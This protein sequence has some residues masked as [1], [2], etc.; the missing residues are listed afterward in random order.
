MMAWP[1]SSHLR[2]C[3][4]GYRFRQPCFC[5][6]RLRRALSLSYVAGWLLLPFVTYDFPGIPDFGKAT[7]ILLGSSIGLLLHKDAGRVLA[8]FRMSWIDVPPIVALCRSARYIDP[9]RPRDLG[10]CRRSLWNVVYVGGALFTRQ[11]RIS[12]RR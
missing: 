8:T 3:Y 7:A 6:C 11:T 2:R 1:I 10:R 4:A 5:V 9:Q 12:V